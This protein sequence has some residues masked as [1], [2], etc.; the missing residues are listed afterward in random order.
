[1]KRVFSENSLLILI[2]LISA[3][4]HGIN[5]FHFPYFENDEGTYISQA[6]S[7]LTKHSLT[8][9][10]YWY[11]HAPF[12]WI[13]IAFWAFLT[14]GFFTFGPS[15]N[16]GRVF[17]LVLHVLSTYFL[18]A[19][20]KKI[21]TRVWPGVLACLIFS[22]SP[23]AIYFQRLVLLDNIMVFLVLLSLWLLL[24]KDLKLRHVYLSAVVFGLSVLTKENAIFFL[25]AF[26]YVLLLYAHKSHKRFV[27][28]KWLT[29]SLSIVSLY[30]LYAFLKN[31]LLP[32]GFLGDKSQHVSLLATIDSQLSRG[33]TLPFWD[34]N[35]D[36]FKS[37]TQ[38]LTADKFTILSGTIAIIAGF[39][40]SIFNKALRLPTFMMLLF[41]V[42]LLR[43]KFVMAFY[44]IPMIPFAALSIG[45]ILDSFWIGFITLCQKGITFFQ[46]KNYS[47]RFLYTGGSV[48]FAFII[49]YV[50]LSHPIGQYTRDE[51]WPEIST[52]N[53]IKKNLPENTHIIVDNSIYVDL[54]A[55]RYKNDKVFPN[56][57]WFWKVEK[58]PA[59]LEGKLGNNWRNISYIALSHE[60]LK[61][62]RENNFVV[63]R[64]A[65]DNS[66]KVADFADKSVYR[67]IGRYVS[68]NGNWMSVYKLRSKD[69]IA[70]SDSWQYYKTHFVHSYGQV[71]DPETGNTTSEGQSYALLRAVWEND[72][73]TFANVWAWT[74]D[75]LQYRS[76]DKLFSWLWAKQGKSEKVIDSASASDAD[77][78][79]ALALL[80]AYSRFGN[81]AYLSSA[82]EIIR[83][84]WRKDVVAVKGR[85][86]LTSG[87]SSEQKTGYLLN[88]SYFSP[89]S[90]RLFALVDPTHP[91]LR[92]VD[93]TYTFLA[94]LNSEGFLLP[95]NWLL[96]EKSGEIGSASSYI[97]K[98]AD[99][100][101]FDAF[102][103][104]W[105]LALDAKWFQEKR[106][107][108][109]LAVR[110]KFF[111]SQWQRDKRFATLYDTKG[112]VGVY[113]QSFSNNAGPLAVMTITNPS[114]ASDVYKT[115]IAK[116]I[117]GQN[118][119]KNAE[120]Y[121][122]QNWIWFASA[123]YNGTAK[124]LWFRHSLDQDYVLSLN[125]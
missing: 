2:L 98:E 83:D 21:T 1:M 65:V 84:I 14:G 93:D 96:L 50:L 27:V 116:R 51:T 121:Y 60:M 49:S 8:P 59:V 73:E 114:L 38:W 31:E 95:P 69:A 40:L 76:G 17:M 53:W 80:F 13:L 37:F 123:L 68:S 20:A 67:D 78:D 16:S 106:A 11:D 34:P 15:V 105:R 64:D 113:Y 4:S 28:F 66:V 81:E 29:V 117:D 77:S 23:I 87:T 103:L 79:I 118:G 125:P 61:Q 10:T 39:F 57:D 33:K 85:Y 94:R 46:H 44:L 112:K 26:I 9:Y 18:F 36:F 30:F 48:L 6:W 12:G 107:V 109:F 42:F 41:L 52:I 55:R 71:I 86:Y 45:I 19:I 63:V 58:D 104:F 72:K 120:S 90:Y 108:N 89:A 3:L 102:R 43:G 22:L 5:M 25:P 111:A 101:G 91:W 74:R 115:L 82:K 119:F 35:S 7:L 100:Y 54:H 62:I 88:P 110:E 24:K 32:S 70:L 47:L 124:N 122:D 97:T 75:H 56:A 99:V 92:L